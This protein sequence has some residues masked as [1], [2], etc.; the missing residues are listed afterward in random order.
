MVD[1]VKHALAGQNQLASGGL[2]L[3][4]IGGLGVYLRAVPER[5][6]YWFKN[7][8]T[9]MIT[10]K[11][12]D[13]AFVWVKE[14]FLEQK[15]LRRIRRVDIDTTVRGEKVSLI[16][17]PGQHWFWHAGRPF[18]VDFYRKEDTKGWQHRRLEWLTFRTM[19]R[20]QEFLRQFVAEVAESHRRK[21]GVQ[22]WLHTYND[23]WEQVE[24]YRPRWLRSVILERD[25]KERMVE[26]VM[27]F[28]QSRERYRRLGVPYHRG[29][30]LHGPPGTGKTSLVSAIAAE[31]EMSIYLVNL[32]EFNDRTLISAVGQV[33]C[34]SVVLFEDIDCMKAGGAR[35]KPEV[36][37]G[38][39]RG[40]ATKDDLASKSGVTLS[41][42]LNVLD[43]F[44]APDDVLFVM[45]SNQIEALDD[46]L[47]RPG[48][49]D[50]RLYMGA[51][52][53][54]QK[55]ELYH[56]FFPSA[57]KVEAD[58]FVAAHPE[59]QTMAE[60]QG[61]LLALELSG[62]CKPAVEAAVL[63]ERLA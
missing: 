41:G 52:T 43:G 45:T 31:F 15:F 58:M 51:A 48:R 8:T 49:I 35:A 63:E 29:Y 4:I 16:P 32:N 24:G 26:D 11:D 56:R 20:R 55:V 54:G 3:M 14:W 5:I 40:P 53:D 47:L 44:H 22:S 60:F 1:F 23:G 18:V 6:W 10:V 62:Q 61:L 46:A 42:L 50:Y 12:D 34:N 38:D 36:W 33:P 21:S 37:C 13:V 39:P 25:E 59:A 7:Q 2:L 19:G 27:N 9:M 57:S 28:K 17:A 30:L